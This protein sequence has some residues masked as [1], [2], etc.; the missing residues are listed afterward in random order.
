MGAALERSGRDITYSCSWPDYEMCD[1]LHQCGNIS[2]V[3]WGAIVDAGCSQWRVW[4]DINCRAA[5]LFEVIDHFGDTQP[6]MVAIHGPGRWFDADQLLIGAGCLTPDEERTQMALWS[7]LAQPL[8]VSADFRNMSA[9]SAA[10]L[11][12]ERAIA[13]DQDSLGRMGARLEDALA[14]LQ[15]WHR[16]LANDDVAVVLLNRHGA[17][18]APCAPSA[19]V[20]NTSGY[21]ECCGGGCCGAFS[22]LTLAA[23]EAQ[24]CAMGQECA[25]LSFPEGAARSGA[26]DSGCF[27]SA[28]DCFQPSSGFI[29]VSKAAW[30]PAP[31]APSDISLRF[32]DVG[33][34][35]GES[36]RVL[37]VWS[38]SSDVLVG[39]YTARAVP[40]HGNAFLRLSRA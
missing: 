35:E 38:G 21:L 14:P 4:R 13:I 3:D 34:G 7:V 17:P 29:G 33:F 2:A 5:D 1:V 19:W 18:P 12:N 25:G 22:N 39:G 30:P 8:F 15:T 16:R 28:L 26:P 31:P 11:L 32:A 23:A 10:V 6:A 37:D 27:K 24:C 20:T 40:Y 9:D 36:V